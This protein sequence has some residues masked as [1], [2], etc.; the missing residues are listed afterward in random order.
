[1][2]TNLPTLPPALLEGCLAFSKQLY[3]MKSGVAKLEI[4]PSHFLFSLNQ[5]PGNNE[6]GPTFSNL[7]QIQRKK[8]PSQ[9]KRDQRRWEEHKERKSTPVAESPP[10]VKKP[11]IMEPPTAVQPPPTLEP[12]QVVEPSQ[13][14]GPPQVA[15]LPQFVES[16]QFVEPSQSVEPPKVVEP[17]QFVDL[18]QVVE[19]PA[20]IVELP[21]AMDSQSRM[22]VD[23]PPPVL[24]PMVSPARPSNSS[25]KL[26]ELPD[27]LLDDTCKL[28]VVISSKQSQSAIASLRRTLKKINQKSIKIET[29]EE[30]GKKMEDTFGYKLNVL[31]NRFKHIVQNINKNWISVDHASILHFFIVRQGKYFPTSFLL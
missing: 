24:S 21:P 29:V 1:M 17:S 16:P 18:Q 22:E 8:T 3:A 25:N 23:Y 5:F 28:L 26:S 11:P 7:D 19:R 12:S 13:A 10:K 6:T 27:E 20:I 30:L 9:R 31:P 15:K 14:V 4:S 2:I